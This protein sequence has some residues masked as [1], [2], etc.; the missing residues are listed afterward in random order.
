MSVVGGERLW[1]NIIT[2]AI[3]VSSLPT[4]YTLLTL[5]VM[6]PELDSASPSSNTASIFVAEQKR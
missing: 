6:V 3:Q 1:S 5:H 2:P 4:C